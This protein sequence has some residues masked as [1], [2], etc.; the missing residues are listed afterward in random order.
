MEDNYIEVRIRFKQSTI[1]SLEK[2]V[3]YFNTRQK[4]INSERQNDMITVE[5]MIRGA[6]VREIETIET[7]NHL[8]TYE[9]DKSLGNRKYV[10]KN[11][12]KEV[13]KEKG[14]K[15]LD[16]VELTGIDRSNISFI[17]N[18]RN[19]PTADYLLR[20]WVALDFYPLEKIFYR[21]EAE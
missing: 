11:R 18:N 14:M 7:Y 2:I 13:L 19:Q 15:Q 9:G 4:L 6:V 5:E 10:L 17:V 21:V 20:I 3:Q 1:D 16:L 12:L 8:I